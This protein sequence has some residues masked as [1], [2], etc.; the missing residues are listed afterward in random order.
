MDNLIDL[1]RKTAA[2]NFKAIS[3]QVLAIGPDSKLMTQAAGELRQE[4]RHTVH[5]ATNDKDAWDILDQK[6]IALMILDA[7]FI[8]DTGEEFLL[9]LRE[10]PIS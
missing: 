1:L 4:E 3:T 8:S 2:E 9:Q 5:R 7:G 10:N 6:N